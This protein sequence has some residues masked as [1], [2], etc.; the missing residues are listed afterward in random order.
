MNALLFL[1]VVLIWGLSWFAIHLQ[2]GAAPVD[3]A[4]FWRFVVSVLMLGGW[5]ALTGRLRR[6]SREVAPWPAG[7][8]ACLFS[9]NFLAFYSSEMFLPSGIVSVVFSMS[10]V[11]NALG[12]WLFFRQR[13]DV[14]VLGGGLLGVCGVA[15]L[16]GGG[17]GGGAAAAMLAGVGLALLG[18]VLFS[19]GNMISRRIGRFDMDLPNAVLCSM[20]FGMFV[21]GVNVLTQGHSFMP[22]LT[23]RWLSGLLYLSVF[24]SVAGFLFYLMLVR[25]IGADR[26]AYTTILSPV[27][28]LAVSAIFE[29]AHW[30]GLMLAGLVLILCGNVLAFARRRAVPRV[31]EVE[32]G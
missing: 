15:M 32:Q 6:P 24:G 27:I 10:T 23:L 3:V 29:G 25:R 31:V 30:S 4:I 5:L 2:M 16:L 12:L 1:A 21:M 7:M 17:L 18:T 13:P 14:R 22:P 28:A 11:L 19:L 9:C 20:A 26:A 8:G